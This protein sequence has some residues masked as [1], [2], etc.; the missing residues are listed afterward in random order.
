MRR[1]SYVVT[2]VGVGLLIGIVACVSL[3]V[4]IAGDEEMCVPSG[5]HHPGTAGF[6][7]G[8]T[9]RRGFPAWPP[10]GSCLQQLPPHLE[11]Y[12]AH[13]RLHDH[14]LSRS[15]YPAQ[16][17][18]VQDHRQGSGVPILQKRIPQPMHRLPQ[19][20]EEGNR[21]DG[22]EHGAHRWETACHRSCRLRRMPS[23]GMRRRSRSEPAC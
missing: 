2:F 23:E 4:A 10:S 8:Q 6:G 22:K 5:D 7:G 17:R 14:R 21:A 9:G 15:R 16:T 11:G 18:R 20:H 19:D 3:G 12:S 13:R 1:Q